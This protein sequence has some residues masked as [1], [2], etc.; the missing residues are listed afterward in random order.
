MAHTTFKYHVSFA[1]IMRKAVPLSFILLALACSTPKPKEYDPQILVDQ[2]IFAHGANLSGKKVSFNFRDRIYTL[3]KGKNSYTYIR[4]W[5]DDSLGFVQDI[6]VNSTDFTRF[7][8]GDS[9]TLDDESATKYARSVESVF[10]FFQIP[11]VLNNQ[12]IIKKYV[13]EFEIRNEPY[14]GVQVTFNE[15]GGGEDHK[16]VFLYWIHKE[17]STIDY[18]AY[19]YLTNG[20]GVRFREA[21]NRRKSGGF[22]VQDYINYKTEKDTHLKD[23]PA[24][25]NQGKLEE[26]S[27]IENTKVKVY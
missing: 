18:L 6:L 9:V 24:L 21:I 1:S 4:S 22:L 11:Y 5:Q 8:D 7:Q 10:Y 2:A 3:R 16:D 12:A 27:R 25:F 26:L 20:G 14:L 19:S 15:E 17:F 23:L 13:G